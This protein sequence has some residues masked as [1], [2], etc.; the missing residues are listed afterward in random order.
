LKRWL[1]LA[2]LLVSTAALAQDA[3][4]G[5]DEIV[6]TAPTEQFAVPVKKLLKAVE[7]YDRDRARLAPQGILWFELSPRDPSKW[8]GL[9][10][11]LSD[12]TTTMPVPLDPSGRFRLPSLPPGDWTLHANRKG[13]SLA[14]RALVRTPGFDGDKRR[15]GDMRLHCRVNWAVQSDRYS[16]FQ[17]AGFNMIG[18]CDTTRIA[19]FFRERHTLAGASMRGKALPIGKEGHSFYAPIGYKALGN[20][21]IIALDIR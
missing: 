8:D 4:P 12:G 3:T 2:P 1:W 11:T 14:F 10:A 5:S 7:A 6:V 20:D 13:S 21:E 19:F 16:I 18:G 17:R 15:L 9:A